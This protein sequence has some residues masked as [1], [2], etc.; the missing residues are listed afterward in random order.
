MDA[1]TA[2]MVTF[3]RSIGLEVEIGE[4]TEE[5]FVPGITLR[6]GRLAVDLDRLKYPGDLLH[7]AGHLAVAT[8]ERRATLSDVGDRP[9]EEMMAIAWSYAA[10][11]HL[12]LDPAIVF[13]AAG[14]RGGSESL[15]ENFRTGHYLA[16]PMLEW[17]GMAYG[18]RRAEQE[19]VAPY[20]AMRLWLRPAPV[21]EETAGAG[22]PEAEKVVAAAPQPGA[23]SAFQSPVLGEE[24]RAN[25]PTDIVRLPFTFDPARLQADLARIQPEEWIP[26]FNNQIFEGRWSGVALRS[27][28]GVTGKLYSGLQERSACTDTPL[29][30]RC[31]YLREVLDTFQCPLQSARLL[32]LEPRSHILR[33]KDPYL[34]YE[35]G[36]VRLHIPIQTDPEVRFYLEGDRVRM[37]VG[38]CWYLNL[39]RHHWVDNFSDTPRVHLVIDCEVNAW[40]AAH[41]PPGMPEIRPPQQVVA[42]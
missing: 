12:G 20:P 40:L 37:E 5:T 33:H 26:H 17:T 27:V 32:M 11:L 10:A 2:T 29:L 30:Q 35:E 18:P 14:Y 41:F 34:G 9:A 36:E 28:G 3:I 24:A 13:H 6:Q 7:E 42:G 25:R 39:S 1:V 19:G 4:V 16:V 23:T 8:P 38:E 15:L 22:V 21:E 31:P